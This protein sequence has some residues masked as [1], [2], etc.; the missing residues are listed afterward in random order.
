MSAW[1]NSQP[2]ASKVEPAQ[3]GAETSATPATE[4]KVAPE[5]QS[6]GVRIIPEEETPKVPE[7]ETP[8]APESDPT[9]KGPSQDEAVATV[10]THIN[11]DVEETTT[12]S[13]PV[14]DVSPP[15]P[16]GTDSEDKTKAQVTE[17]GEKD[18]VVERASLESKNAGEDGEVYIG[19]ATWEE[20]TWKEVVKLREDMFWARVGGLR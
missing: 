13:E 6:G 12:S 11:G 3:P 14:P 5:V 20:R 19:D 7:Q 9:P 10:P 16:I 2:P 17:T 15:P 8:K 1:Q 4:A 18:D